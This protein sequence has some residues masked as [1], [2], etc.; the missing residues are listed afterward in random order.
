MKIVQV[1]TSLGAGGAEKILAVL[2][3]EFQ[4]AGHSVS[5]I[6]LQEP[7]ENKRIPA[8]LEASQTPVTY[9]GI[10]KWQ[11]NSVFLLRKAIR[12]SGADIVHSHLMHPNILCR[13]AMKGL[14]IP[15]VNTIHISERRKGKKFFFIMDH[16]TF[17]LADAM[18]AVSHASARFHARLCRIP[19]DSIRT[20]YNGTEQVQPPSAERVEEIRKKWHLAQYNKVIGTIGRLDYQKGFDRLIERAGAIDQRIPPGERWLLMI[21][22]DGPE[23]ENLQQIID[24]LHLASLDIRLGGFQSD[25]AQLM[26]LFNVFIMPS[27]YEGYGLALAE[28]MTL[29]LPVVTSRVDSLPELCA[30]YHGANRLVNMKRDY[31]GKEMADAV[32]AMLRAGRSK[33]DVLQSHAGMAADYLKLYQELVG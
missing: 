29:G 10:R 8:M 19:S 4:E 20:I 1:I 9:L 13:L 14:H 33:G 28:A 22:G 3:R 25:A 24:R 27:R 6:S 26:S 31:E 16:L 21:L 15:L 7:P 30:Q 11:W 23:R 18:T 17:R 32:F 12:E 5:V 2:A